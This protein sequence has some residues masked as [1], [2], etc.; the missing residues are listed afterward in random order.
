MSEEFLPLDEDEFEDEEA[1][2]NRNFLV[3]AGSLVGVLILITICVLAIA[4]LRRDGGTDDAAATIIAQNATTEADNLLITQTIQAM[5][6]DAARP[7]D[8]PVPTNTVLP[9]NTPSPTVAP[10]D[11][12]VVQ[13]PEGDG[14]EVGGGDATGTPI[15]EA[16]SIFQGGTFDTP[17]PLSGTGTGD[18]TLPQTGVGTAGAVLVALALLGI[19]VISRRLRTN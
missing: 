15:A 6:T 5:E 11:T 3:I 2:A 17:T 16:T 8:T 12:P 18:G 9:T 10:T 14:E 7:T 4:F 19:L 13:P 1:G